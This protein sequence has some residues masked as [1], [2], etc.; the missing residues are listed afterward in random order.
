M[1]RSTICRGR[2]PDGS[3]CANP[4][5][6]PRSAA[7]CIH[8]SAR[9][10]A[11]ASS[12]RDRTR[13]TGPTA[14]RSCHV[15]SASRG[16]SSTAG[17]APA[18]AG[19]PTRHA[20]WP[21]ITSCR[22]VRT[23]HEPSTGRT[24]SAFAAAATRASRRASGVDERIEGWGGTKTGRYRLTS[25]GAVVRAAEFGLIT[26]YFGWVPRSP[27]GATGRPLHGP[28]AGLVASPEVVSGAQPPWREA[29]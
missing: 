16:S 17:P 24:C 12:A 13:S 29:R 18:S 5:S 6:D 28:Q 21:P 7:R 10:S 27:T 26:P 23:T 19:P 8:S 22:S 15:A 4:T 20:T 2:E 9:A 14:G 11:H 1:P 25:A 3:P